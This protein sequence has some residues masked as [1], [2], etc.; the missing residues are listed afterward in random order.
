MPRTAKALALQME[1][2]WNAAEDEGRDL[3]PAERSEMEELVL[4]AKA[5]HSIEKQIR[6]LDP[7]SV[8]FVTRQDGGAAISGGPGDVFVKFAGIPAGL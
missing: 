2:M 8:S 3:T 5:Q 7:G 1:A 6:E 4:A